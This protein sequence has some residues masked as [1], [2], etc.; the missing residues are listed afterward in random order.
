MFRQIVGEL[1]KRMWVP[2]FCCP[3]DGPSRAG[4][5][6]SKAAERGFASMKRV[7]VTPRRSGY[8]R[9]LGGESA[10]EQAVAAQAQEC[11]P[12]PPAVTS[13]PAEQAPLPGVTQDPVVEMAV[14]PAA[15]EEMLKAEENLLQAQARQLRATIA[16]RLRIPGSSSSSDNVSAIVK[17]YQEV[18]ADIELHIA[19]LHL[20]KR[21]SSAWDE[22]STS[23][24]SPVS[25]QSASSLC[26]SESTFFI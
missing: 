12:R 11:Q 8:P 23:T 16:R 3:E 18:L 19:E 5:A 10:S 13:E 6:C 26:S 17:H 22:A 4:R 14:I 21:S 7:L 2:T 25:I 1:S 24:C 20:R 15:E 9:L